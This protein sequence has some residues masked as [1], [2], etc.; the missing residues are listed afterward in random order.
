MSLIQDDFGVDVANPWN[1]LDLYE[2][3]S[4]W[5][6]GKAYPALVPDSFLK[7]SD[8]LR[9]A[10]EVLRR[11]PRYRMHFKRLTLSNLISEDAFFGRIS[12]LSKRDG[13]FRLFPR[14]EIIKVQHH[15]CSPAAKE[16]QL[17]G[18]Y[19]EEH[20]SVDWMVMHGHRWAM[21]FWGTTKLID[22]KT[23]ADNID[24]VQFFSPSKPSI[25]N[26]LAKPSSAENSLKPQI[27][28]N[29][30]PFHYSTVLTP[31][32]IILRLRSDL[33][34]AQQ[35]EVATALLTGIQLKRGMKGAGNKARFTELGT[36]SFWLRTWDFQSANNAR[37]RIPRSELIRHLDETLS[38]LDPELKKFVEIGQ[39]ETFFD[40]LHGGLTSRKIDNWRKRT[41]NYIVKDQDFYRNLLAKAFL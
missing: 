33:P 14:W 36:A 41:K 1:K 27:L 26:P 11:A 8:Y 6:D 2:P 40:W 13:K 19:A 38:S 30:I 22:P 37:P 31:R 39:R 28:G 20:K 21:N 24:L 9:M 16:G 4:D 25:I 3:V 7:Q 18:D 12:H 35:I 10:W 23:Q 5:T 32:E 17:F 15:Y 29:E 34:A